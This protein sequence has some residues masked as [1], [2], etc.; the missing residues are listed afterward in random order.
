MTFSNWPMW[1]HRTEAVR[2]PSSASP[3]LGR[4]VQ[5][6]SEMPDDGLIA[7]SIPI[8]GN[9]GSQSALALLLSNGGK[10]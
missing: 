10:K 1:G 9:V 6:Y 3:N 2:V 8:T 4:I 5:L 7:A